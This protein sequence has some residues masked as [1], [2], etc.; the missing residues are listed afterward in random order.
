MQLEGRQ[1][2]GEDVGPRFV[3]AQGVEHGKTDVAARDAAETGGLEDRVQ[4][5]GRGG[6]AV[7][8]GDDQPPTGRSVDLGAV[9]APGQ[10]DVAPDG[11]RRAGRARE[12]RGVGRESGT[13]DH[14]GELAQRSGV[15]DE[16]VE[17]D[18]PGAERRALGQCALVAV[19]DGD[20]G[21]EIGEGFDRRAAGDPCPGD[22]HRPSS[23]PFEFVVH[24]QSPIAARYSL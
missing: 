3:A 4:H 14:Q 18:R 6:L 17:V 10:F 1:L 23:E 11:D 20:V 19:G 2:H 21:A 13:R 24:G 15:V 5:H 7:R 16:A 8:P 22:E 12:Q 9:D